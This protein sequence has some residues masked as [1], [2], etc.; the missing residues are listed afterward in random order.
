MKF[1]ALF[2][3][4]RPRCNLSYNKFISLTNRLQERHLRGYGLHCILVLRRK[5]EGRTVPVRPNFHV[6]V[7][8]RCLQGGFDGR[9][10]GDRDKQHEE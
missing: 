2:S 6:P 1:G 3:L 7:T 8:Q 5:P 4:F 10:H 9:K